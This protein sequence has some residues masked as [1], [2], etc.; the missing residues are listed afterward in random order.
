M[1]RGV[2]TVV[3]ERPKLASVMM[4]SGTLKFTR[5]KILKKSAWNLNFIVSVI[6]IRL[7]IEKSTFLKFGPRNVL[8]PMVPC[9]PKVGAAPAG[10]IGLANSVRS[11]PVCTRGFG[12][13]D[14]GS[15]LVGLPGLAKFAR[16]L[17]PELAL[18]TELKTRKG[19]PDWKVIL[20]VIVQLPR[21]R[22]SHLLSNLS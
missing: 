1:T 8:R 10:G 18:S 12:A 3:S 4:L 2:L 14:V 9:I 21:A 7:I 13:S 16:W 19:S 5:L 17:T 11:G 6:G 22:S 20:P 15:M